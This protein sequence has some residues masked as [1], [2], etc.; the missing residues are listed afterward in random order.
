MIK[1]FE[2]FFGDRPLQSF[3]YEIVR[4][5]SI[6]LATSPKKSKGAVDLTSQSNVNRKLALLLRK[7]FYVAVQPAN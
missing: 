2:A 7:I 3:N 5:Y 6:N 1:E 4:S